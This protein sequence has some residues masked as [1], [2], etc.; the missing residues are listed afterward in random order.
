MNHWEFDAQH[1]ESGS[2]YIADLAENVTMFLPRTNASTHV[3]GTSIPIQPPRNSVVHVV[4]PT[5]K[6]NLRSMDFGFFCLICSARSC[7]SVRSIR[8]YQHL[9][10]VPFDNADEFGDSDVQRSEC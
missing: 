5:E 2:G 9:P 7:R 10:Q 8:S 4:D 6:T 1:T 3:L